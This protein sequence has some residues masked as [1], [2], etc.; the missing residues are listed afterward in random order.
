MAAAPARAAS[1][2]HDERAEV[3]AEDRAQRDLD[4]Q[5]DMAKWAFWMVILTVAQVV[6]AMVSIYF[7]VRSVRQSSAAIRKATEANAI[8]Q[9]NHVSEQRAWLQVTDLEVTGY[10]ITDHGL[11]INIDVSMINVGASPARDI[12]IDLVATPREKF[13]PDAAVKTIRERVLVDPIKGDGVVFAGASHTVSTTVPLLRK[14]IEVIP[15][16]FGT[17]RHLH[18]L[19]IGAVRYETIFASETAK[20]SGFGVET[21]TSPSTGFVVDLE[22]GLL[23][24]D[25]VELV[26]TQRGWYAD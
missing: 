11:E 4:A 24:V 20:L 18:F 16:E 6:V 2:I 19:L 14:Q 3:K 22:K 10:A 15:P 26:R 21:R 5:E 23:V 13:F 12:W 1:A 17:L 7:L 8:A 9:S 25:D